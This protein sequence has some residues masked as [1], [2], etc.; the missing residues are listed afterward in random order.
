MIILILFAC[1]C[2]TNASDNSTKIKP[3]LIKFNLISS[4]TQPSTAEMDFVLRTHGKCSGPTCKRKRGD[5]EFRTENIETQCS[6]AKCSCADDCHRYDRCCP[7]LLARLPIKEEWEERIYQCRKAQIK[8][9]NK[10]P[11]YWKR[12]WMVSKCPKA[13]NDT[14]LINIFK[15]TL[16][17]TSLKLNIPITDIKTKLTYQN[18]YYAICHKVEKENWRAWQSEVRCLST[19]HRLSTMSIIQDIR[20]SKD[21]DVVF[22]PPLDVEEDECEDVVSDCNITGLWARHDPVVEAACHAF[23]SV[24]NMLYRNIFC[25]ICNGAPDVRVGCEEKTTFFRPIAFSALLDLDIVSEENPH[26]SDTGHCA[27]NEIYDQV[28]MICRQIVCMEGMSLRNGSCRCL[29]STA[30]GG[31]CYE[32]FI[33]FTPMNASFDPEN[34]SSSL[35]SNLRIYFRNNTSNIDQLDIYIENST[36]V[37]RHYFFVRSVL[38]VKDMHHPQIFIDEFLNQDNLTITFTEGIFP[39]VQFLVHLDKITVFNGSIVS[40]QNG[41]SLT[42]LSAILTA[43]SCSN[44]ESVKI[45]NFLRCPLIQ[46]PSNGDGNFTRN[47]TGVYFRNV[48]LWFRND[49]FVDGKDGESIFMC[50]NEYVGKVSKFLELVGRGNGQRANVYWTPEG[51]L[52][53][54]VIAMSLICLC[55]TVVT[56]CLFATLRTQPGKNNMGLC[57]TLIVAYLAQFGIGATDNELMC[58]VIGILIHFSWLSVLF[59]MNVCC[60]HM[61]KSM[62]TLTQLN[63]T[64]S[65]SYLTVKYELFV[66]VSSG[67][68]VLIN[69]VFSL[70]NSDG[71]NFGYGGV[72]CFVNSKLMLVITF[73][74]IIGI[75]IVVNF[76]F[77]VAIIIKL[78]NIHQL[79]TRIKNDKQYF[80]VYARLSSITGFTWIFILIYIVT[81]RPIFAYLFTIFGAG[82]GML[83]FVAFT[84]NRR[85]YEMYIQYIRQKW[86]LPDVKQLS[87]I[88]SNTTAV[89]TSDGF[90]RKL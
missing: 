57:L 13:F 34:F 1:I 72:I 74:L 2:N 84:F 11:I 15:E 56:Y 29:Y 75:V 43:S 41:L 64:K 4:P 14:Y 25:S 5:S 36:V 6:C 8:D 33:R 44:T 81:K 38:H 71:E 90:T 22:K 18:R 53:I 80:K 16:N 20:N 69:V 35:Y 37:T 19:S 60:F 89:T 77:F 61:Y 87:T 83:I 7:D 54:V 24:F 79:D 12:Y 86:P 39:N 50:A 67:L 45:T 10:S 63:A 46:F 3:K 32:V 55:M 42:K 30:T 65:G 9:S 17:S 28:N 51:I 21:C 59:W 62:M 66:L 73:A 47:M 58:K 70:V 78:R 49:E 52:S 88:E 23:T 85:T 40:S 76:G 82:Q 68:M 27:A 48:A 31:M 26:V